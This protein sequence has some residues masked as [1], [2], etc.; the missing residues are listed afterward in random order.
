MESFPIRLQL[1]AH[2]SA[3]PSISMISIQIA[4]LNITW[5]KIRFPWLYSGI[6][7]KQDILVFRLKSPKLQSLKPMISRKKTQ[8]QINKAIEVRGKRKK[9]S[10][11]PPDNF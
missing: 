8:I 4:S 2:Q 5:V 9:K 6:K 3:I 7:N 11:P 10:N 1:L